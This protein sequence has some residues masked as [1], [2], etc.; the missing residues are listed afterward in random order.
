MTRAPCCCPYSRAATGGPA[1]Q[2]AQT[3]NSSSQTPSSRYSWLPPWMRCSVARGALLTYP[4]TSRTGTRVSSVQ[5]THSS[6]TWGGIW[7]HARSIGM[8][9]KRSSS[10]C[11]R[12]LGLFID[13]VLAFRS[14]G[15]TMKVRLVDA[16]RH[17]LPTPLKIEPESPL[18]TQ[19]GLIGLAHGRSE[20]AQCQAS[21]ASDTSVI[22]SNTPLIAKRPEAQTTLGT[23]V[24][25]PPAQSAATL[26]PAL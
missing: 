3:L 22:V 12:R 4:A 20:L 10:A 13:L 6:S 1:I 2:R 8:A 18:A 19:G 26:A 17:F 11:H 5:W 23:P 9:V 7:R 21:T 14:L 25:R 16:E 15:V 24:P